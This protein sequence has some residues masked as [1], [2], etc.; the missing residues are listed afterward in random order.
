M[1]SANVLTHALIVFPAVC[2]L[3]VTTQSRAQEDDSTVSEMEQRRQI[4]QH[5]AELLRAENFTELEKVADEYRTNKT[6][7]PSG[8]WK[9]YNFYEGVEAPRASS[10]GRDWELH[11]ARLE[12]WRA[13]SPQS[14]TA[15]TALAAA[16]VKYAWQARGSGYGNTV[17]EE[18]WQLFRER[19]HKAEGYVEDARKLPSVDP[20][21]DYVNLILARG[22]GWEWP[23]YNAVFDDAV[24]REPG[25]MYLYFQKATYALPRWSGKRGDV[26]KFAL[27][28]MRLTPKTDGKAMYARLAV[29]LKQ[30][31]GKDAW[32]FG[33]YHLSWPDVKEGFRDLEKRYPHSLWNLNQF[34]VTACHA[35]D[36]QTA[37]E[38]FERIGDRWDGDVWN[39][40]GQYRKWKNWAENPSAHPDATGEKAEEP[41]LWRRILGDLL[42]WW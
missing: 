39:N 11:L 9:L 6:R 33:A 20:H 23:R 37:H 36:S 14:I 7:L 1:K 26:E 34:C 13:Q 31:L 40:E 5:T 29:C 8:F 42:S 32:L 30:Y 38:L 18:G 17:T 25:Y 24:K 19:L 16:Y 22:L 27:A 12:K 21:L 28:A 4:S 41:S 15:H 35:K 10:T 3:C 2:F